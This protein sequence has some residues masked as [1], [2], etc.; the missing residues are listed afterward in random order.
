[1][2]FEQPQ[3]LEREREREME[4]ESVNGLWEERRDAEGCA[5]AGD[6]DDNDAAAAV[7]HREEQTEGG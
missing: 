7:E 1:M 5:G 4:K 2:T 6:G 3:R